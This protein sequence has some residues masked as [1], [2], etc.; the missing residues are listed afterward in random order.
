MQPRSCSKAHNTEMG[1]PGP[2]FGVVDAEPSE[3]L[4]QVAGQAGGLP[5][6]IVER[7]HPDAAGLA[8]TGH[9]ERHGPDESFQYTVDLVAEMWASA[10]AEEGIDSFLQK[11]AP[12]WRPAAA[13]SIP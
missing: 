8:V 11:R 2:V 13:T 3:A 9:L 6:L 1:E 12:S 4:V 5:A 7:E 10:E